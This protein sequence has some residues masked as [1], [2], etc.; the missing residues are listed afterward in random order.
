[1]KSLTSVNTSITDLKHADSAGLSCSALAK[2]ACSEANR[3]TMGQER[4]H[5][6]IQ[7][8][9]RTHA[10]DIELQRKACG[11]SLLC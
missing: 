10:D 7:A 3:P 1:M 4:V 5:I 11:Y 9:M 2:L 8:A 6:E